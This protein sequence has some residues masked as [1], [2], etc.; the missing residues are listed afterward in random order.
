MTSPP[1]TPETRLLWQRI[2]NHPLQGDQRL[3][4]LKRLC[5]EQ[6]WTTAYGSQVIEEYK[7]FVFLSCVT[8]SSLTPSIDIDETWHLHLT[9]TED[10]WLTFC[11]QVLERPLHHRPTTGSAADG[12]KF[13]EQYA[14][15]LQIYFAW[16]G[17]PDRVIWP[18]SKQRFDRPARMQRINR[19]QF[20]IVRKPWIRNSI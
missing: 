7:R 13:R 9:Y 1:W 20:W 18:S 5:R 19:D 8:S 3:D 10:Y 4:F 11:P 15:T 16:F 12:Q 17:P 14:Q 2:S 6:R